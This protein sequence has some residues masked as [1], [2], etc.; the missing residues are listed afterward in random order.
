MGKRDE[1]GWIEKTKDG[2]TKRERKKERKKED[3]KKKR[4]KEDRHDRAST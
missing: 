4:E 1:F 3:D 2:R